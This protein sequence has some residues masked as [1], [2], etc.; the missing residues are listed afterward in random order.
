MPSPH[1]QIQFKQLPP[2]QRNGGL[3]A[4]PRPSRWTVGNWTKAIAQ[5]RA[6]RHLQLC[7]PTAISFWRRPA[8]RAPSATG[9]V[10]LL[11][12]L[13]FCISLSMATAHC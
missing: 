9:F 3:G 5:K 6:P 8:N 13:P 4:L 2:P 12:D 7:S 1:S 11:K 10:A